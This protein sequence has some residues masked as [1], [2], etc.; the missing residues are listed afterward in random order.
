M[1][2]SKNGAKASTEGLPKGKISSLKHLSGYLRPY[3]GQIAA[4]CFALLFTSSSVLAIGKALQYL[5]DSGIAAGNTE[6]LDAYYWRMLLVVCVLAAATYA[7]YYFISRVGEM[8]IAD[9]RNDV[10]RK[11]MNMDCAFFETTRSGDILSRLTTDTTLLQ[12]VVGSSVSIFLR[13]VIMGIGGMAMLVITSWHLTGYVGLILPLVIAPIIILGKKVRKLS[14]ETQEKVSDISVHAEESLHAIRTV[15]AMSLEETES[16]RFEGFV[17]QAKQ[18]ALKRIRVRS[19]LTAIVIVLIFGAIVSVLWIGGRDVVSGNISGGDL[20]AFIF[21]AIV[22][23]GALG[24]I[25]EVIGELQRAAGAAERLMELKVMEPSIQVTQNPASLP[26]P[27]K[28]VIDFEEIAFHYPSRPNTS[29]LSDFNLRVE[30]GKTVALVG[31]SGAGKSTVFQMLLRFYDPQQ[32]RITIDGMDLREL[33]PSAFRRHIGLVPQ[34]ATIFSADVW[35]NIRCGK[36]DAT[37]DEVRLVAEKA[38][39]LE[40]IDALPEG[41]DSYLGEKGVRLSGG[42]RQRIA[43]ARAL[44]RDPQILLLDEATSALDSE[45]E[46]LV[47]QALESAMT[48]RTTLVIAHRLS[49]ILKAD[50]IVVLNEGRIAAQGTHEELLKSSQLYA[51]LAK[52]QFDVV[53]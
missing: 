10:F 13:N 46:R 22:T 42:Q 14:R 31:P 26:S 36:S 29:A 18:V 25:S 9:I 27:L 4:A 40:F 3:R 7:R 24:A 5:I 8:V 11:L 44:L 37:D 19:A 1:R 32:G 20:S 47:Q 17:E 16:T 38:A 35:H 41:F 48:G 21:Y 43:I 52:L 33:E 39:A 15:Q 53:S 30:S 49:T 51:N 23:A 28:G 34:D 12:N 50:K 45:N 6:L 2:H